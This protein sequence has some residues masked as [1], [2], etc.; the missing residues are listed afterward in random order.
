VAG[1]IRPIE[2]SDDVIRNRTRKLGELIVEESWE[3]LVSN[4]GWEGQLLSRRFSR[5][6]LSPTR[7]MQECYAS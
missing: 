2:E 6:E 4:L 7:D 3:A 1:R 5:F